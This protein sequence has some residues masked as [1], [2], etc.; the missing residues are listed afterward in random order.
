MLDDEIAAGGPR[1][2]QDD[3]RADHLV[4]LL[5]VLVR[6]EEL[7]GLVEEHRVQPRP[8]RALRW[9]TQVATDHV[10]H[11]TKRAVPAAPVDPRSRT[12]DLPG[13]ANPSIE[14]RLV[15]VAVPRGT[16]DESELLGLGSGDGQTELAYTRDLDRQ[17]VDRS[18]PTRG[19]RT[20]ARQAPQQR[21]QILAR[22]Q[23]HRPNLL[24]VIADTPPS[25]PGA[26]IAVKASIDV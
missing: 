25:T 17:I 4:V 22:A 2:K 7:P 5:R 18:G 24:P 26:L 10:Q 16:G 12:G 9:Q 20:A 14:D 1:R 11:R 13:V 21:G 3:Q 6:G 8:E 15:P 19:E 23:G